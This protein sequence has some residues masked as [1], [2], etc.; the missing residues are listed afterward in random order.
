MLKGNSEQ[1]PPWTIHEGLPH[2][3]EGS[4]SIASASWQ[5]CSLF[6]MSAQATGWLSYGTYS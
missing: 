2:A 5:V 1:G 6:G 3:A 4:S